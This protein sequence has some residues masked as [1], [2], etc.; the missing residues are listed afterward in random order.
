[1]GRATALRDHFIGRSDELD[2]LAEAFDLAVR[3][4]RI[5]V[6]LTGESGVGKSFL[7]A[8]FAGRLG[9]RASGLA[10]GHSL[11]TL[12]TPFLP[13]F[14]IFRDLGLGSAAAELLPDE[15]LSVNSASND[16]QIRRFA[17]M[18]SLLQQPRA[19]RPNLITIED[20]QWADSATLSFLEYLGVTRSQGPLLVILTV[21]SDAFDRQ[22]GFARGLARMRAA[23]LIM[24]PLRGMDRSEV[25]EL[26]RLASPRPIERASAER[27]KDLAEGNP[28]FAEELLRATLDGQ[29]ITHASLS[30]VRATV[31]ERFYQLS[32]TDQRIL[33]CA[34]VV[35]RV[36]DVRL[37]ATLMERPL[38]EILSGLRRARNVQL[39]RENA[40]AASHEVG[41]RHAMFWD[42][43]YGELLKLESRELHTRAAAAIEGGADVHR[44]YG[45]LAYHW[46]A[47]GDAERALRYCILAGDEAEKIAAFEDAAR[48]YEKALEATLPGTEHYA[49][50]AAKRAYAWYAAGVLERTP[51]PFADAI[52]A[53]EAIGAHDKVAEMT[54]F[55]SRQAW[56]DAETPA[57]YEHALRAITLIGDRD[58][59]LRDYAITMAASQAVH[60]G[61]PEQA[62]ELIERTTPSSALDIVARRLDTIGIALCR[63]GD[64]HGAI[65]AMQQ[66][67]V[68][69]DGAADPDVVVRVYSNS[70]DVAAVYGNVA[71]QLEHWERAY[72][73]A[74][75]GGYIGRMAY[76]AL[77][78][79]CASIDCGDLSKARELYAMALATGVNNASVAILE[80][81]AGSLLRAL[82]SDR[83]PSLR[84][85]AEALD[86]ALRSTESV[87]IGQTGFAFAFSAIAEQRLDDA[88]VILDRTVG[89]LDAAHFAEM[90]LALGGIYASPDV[91]KRARDLLEPLAGRRE[92]AFARAAYDMICAHERTGSSRTSVLKAVADHWGQLR[93][94]LLQTV[95]LLDAGAAATARDVLQEIG[96]T[97]LVDRLTDYAARDSRAPMGLTKR[98]FEVARLIAD[99]CSNR[100]IGEQLGISERTVE[101]HVASILSRLGIRSRWLLTPQLL[102]H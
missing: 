80:A 23:G 96:A 99:G 36:F 68:A 74:R 66:A 18:S 79:A 88:R 54:M 26:I 38:V 83:G 33:N 98:E 73:A 56:N 52:S 2:A 58:P 10:F 8:E 1:M 60:L 63:Q 72:T 13:L 21:R 42:V 81:C 97:P 84:T 100:A 90:L 78:Y 39:V 57:G 25:G 87:R 29:G 82:A 64:S 14:E 101:H 41:F 6:A 92:N 77:G 51:E 47:A 28:L 35:G 19:S 48:F 76:A 75:D 44:R 94:P 45:E 71:G 7:A 3:G 46:R 16:A 61:R 37:V 31:L 95:A 69:A 12:Q 11:Q 30:S 70:A 5:I 15:S 67:R 65:E 40:N 9:E 32:E 91:R 49:E 50:L 89:A 85:E 20:L 93:R 102:E 24:I 4:Q 43:I 55:L 59:A 22:R 62:R 86:V 34:A 53:F 17:G 27:I